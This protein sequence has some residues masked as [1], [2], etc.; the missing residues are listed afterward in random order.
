MKILKDGI[1]PENSRERRHKCPHCSCEFSYSIQE[2]KK[3]ERGINS[4][5]FIDC[6][7]CGTMLKISNKMV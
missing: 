1:L 5:H 2:A 6:P 7:Y 3:V 4:N